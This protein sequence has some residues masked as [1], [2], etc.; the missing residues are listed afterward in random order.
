MDH[1]KFTLYSL[2]Q[3]SRNYLPRNKIFREVCVGLTEN[4]DRYYRSSFVA[5]SSG[6]H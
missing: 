4:I 5:S 3:T 6:R 2:N 1:L